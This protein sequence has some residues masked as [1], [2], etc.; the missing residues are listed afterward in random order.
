M[1][2]EHGF[3]FMDNFIYILI[4]LILIFFLISNGVEIYNKFQKKKYLSEIEEYIT[5]VK[6]NVNQYMLN[7]KNDTYYIPINCIVESDNQ[8]WSEA[9]VIVTYQN[10]NYEYYWTSLD[11]NG[12]Y[13]P[14]VSEKNLKIEVIEENSAKGIKKE[15]IGSS[16]HIRI[17]NESCTFSA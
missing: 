11:K 5:E 8:K 6:S 17:L 4:G 14:I 7:E 9:Y 10:N 1:K 15:T 12:N 16:K 3:S 13:I 2:N